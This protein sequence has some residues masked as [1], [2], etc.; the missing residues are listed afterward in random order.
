MD[1]KPLNRDAVRGFPKDHLMVV[2]QRNTRSWIGIPLE[3]TDR[4]VELAN[5]ASKET[6]WLGQPST[7][8]AALRP[9]GG[10]TFGVGEYRLPLED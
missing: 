2:T 3:I 10:I 7:H 9:P 6:I 4:Y 1:W 5:G 8:F